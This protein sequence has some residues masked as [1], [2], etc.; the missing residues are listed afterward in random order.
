MNEILSG[1]FS[2]PKTTYERLDD[3]FA[4]L[5][6]TQKSDFISKNIRYCMDKAI[7]EY[8]ND[9]FLDILEYI[10]FERIILYMTENGYNV[11]KK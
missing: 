7:G 10:T 3:D 6:K 1:D 9:Y 8:A 11:S 2:K 5:S 4:K